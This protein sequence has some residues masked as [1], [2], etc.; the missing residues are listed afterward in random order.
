MRLIAELEILGLPKMTNTIG[1]KHWRARHA[2]ARKWKSLVV[3]ACLL[4][5]IQGLKLNQAQITFT[6]YSS[7]EPDFDGLASGFKHC[8]DGLKVAEVI[9]DDKPSV[10]GSPRYFWIQAPQRQGKI[11]IKV[12]A[13]D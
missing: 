11:Q 2:E 5:R 7:K 3:E 8:L 13:Y 10:I 4:K 6:R 1:H 12:E 9:I